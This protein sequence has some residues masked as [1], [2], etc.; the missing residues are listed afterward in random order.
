MRTIIKFRTA[1]AV[2]AVMLLLSC[3]KTGS[4]ADV[5]DENTPYLILDLR[6]LAVTDSTITLK[7]TA[8][9]DDADQ[10]TATTYDLRY[11]N[12]WLTA[13][14]W[15]SATQV[16]GEPSPQPA[17]ET[18]SMLVGG[19]LTDSTYYFAL[20]AC[21]EAGNWS[22]RSNCVTATCFDNCIVSFPDSNLET[23]IRTQISMPTGDI[24][25]LDLINLVYIDGNE[26]NIEDLSGLEYCINLQGI[27][28]SWN[29]ISDIEA[30]ANLRHLL[31]VQF[32]G[33]NLTALPDLSDWTDL[34]G[35]FLTGNDISDVSSLSN[36][37]AIHY[38]YM[39]N[40]DISDLSPLVANTGLG[41]GDSVY[42]DNNP[43]S[44]ESLNDHIPALENRGVY[45]Y[46]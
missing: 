31:E 26:R 37:P 43:L 4:N 15:D 1:G 39:G 40:N 28:M 29:N 24:H 23:A 25:R 46:H 12:D 5:D 20:N 6:T 8:T 35:L 22:G 27:F 41:F 21:D 30:A 42:F 14:N 2:I 34:Q 38:L 13:E 36:L 32:M 33:N 19:L 3:S 7:W 9:G 45:V 18:D 16:S 11:Y 10:G 17:G 44:E